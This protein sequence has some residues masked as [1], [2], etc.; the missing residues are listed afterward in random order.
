VGLSLPSGKVLLFL[1]DPALLDK[2][3]LASLAVAVASTHT[4]I[5]GQLCSASLS[6]APFSRALLFHITPFPISTGIINP[7]EIAHP[8]SWCTSALQIWLAMRGSLLVLV[9][10]GCRKCSQPR[11]D[12]LVGLVHRSATL[13]NAKGRNTADLWLHSLFQ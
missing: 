8:L 11:P 10:V 1:L 7:L 4:L 9:G 6:R 2:N 13:R 5:V 12:A 3:V